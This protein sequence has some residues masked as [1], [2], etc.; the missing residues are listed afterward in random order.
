MS[1]DLWGWSCSIHE[2]GRDNE[3]VSTIARIVLLDEVGRVLL[4]RIVDP[5][6]YKLPVWITPG[7]GIEVGET[8]SQAASRELNEETGLEPAR[9]TSA[10][11]SRYVGASGNFVE[12]RSSRRTGSSCC[13]QSHSNRTPPTG[14][15]WSEN[16]IVAGSGGQP[17]TS[18][19]PARSLFRPA[20]LAWR[21]LFIVGKVWRSP[22]YFP[23]RPPELGRPLRTSGEFNGQLEEG[24][25]DRRQHPPERSAIRAPSDEVNCCDNRHERSAWS[26]V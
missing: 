23:G 19:P 7:G 13:A 2:K 9:L 12:R 14:R 6:E 5:L 21:E 25:P 10:G 11:R 1:T 26:G 17:R 24:S 20:S 16:S 8:M 22:S 3:R 4:F 15:N 18:R